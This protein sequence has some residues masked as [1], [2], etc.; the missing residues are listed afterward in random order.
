MKKLISVLGIFAA[1][2]C[3]TGCSVFNIAS[4]K[5]TVKYATFEG[6]F[7]YIKSDKGESYDLTNDED[8]PSFQKDGLRV[9]FTVKTL[10]TRNFT[11]NWAVEQAEILSIEEL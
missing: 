6:G 8:Y 5:G 3:L 9:R 2:A 7:Y 1:L 10:D 11:H 4:G